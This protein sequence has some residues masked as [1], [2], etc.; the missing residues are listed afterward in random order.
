MKTLVCR[1][2]FLSYFATSPI[3]ALVVSRIVPLGSSVA[4]DLVK[5][6]SVIFL[7]LSETISNFISVGVNQFISPFQYSAFVV[8]GVPPPTTL[9]IFYMYF[10]S[11]FSSNSEN[12]N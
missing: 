6:K 5:P 11:Q 12:L 1:A 8:D 4:E 2:L 3:V 10:I 7:L 9:A